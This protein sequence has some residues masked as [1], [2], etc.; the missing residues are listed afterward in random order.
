MGTRLITL[1]QS[2]VSQCIIPTLVDVIN[3]SVTERVKISQ[4]SQIGQL[5]MVYLMHLK[6]E[7]LSDRS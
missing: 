2:L 6:V 3:P 5:A 4:I 7:P 1:S